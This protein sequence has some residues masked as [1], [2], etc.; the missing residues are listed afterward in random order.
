MTA[1]VVATVRT[2][3]SGPRGNFDIGVHVRADDII[4]IGKFNPSTRAVRVSATI[5]WIKSE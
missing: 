3:A 5:Q 1:L 4:G 2:G